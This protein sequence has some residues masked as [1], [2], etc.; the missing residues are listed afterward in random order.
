LGELEL[1][2]GNNQEAASA[3]AK[4]RQLR[5]NDSTSAFYEGQARFAMG[6][7]SGAR[8][9]LEASLRLLPEQLPARILLAKTYL[10]LD[11]PGSAEDQLQAALLVDSGNADAQLELGRVL[12]AEKKY[13]EA[14]SQLKS[15]TE[16][17]PTAESFELLKQA[18]AGQGKAQLA[19]GA[20]KRAAELK[21][22]SPPRHSKAGNVQ[23]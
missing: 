13:A 6:D 2:A 9:A 8:D 10:R 23:Q 15:V 22:T 18:Y 1:K 20:A 14:V 12:L 4:A 3:L 19:A 11:K 5:P 16:Q 17:H 7:F 21:R